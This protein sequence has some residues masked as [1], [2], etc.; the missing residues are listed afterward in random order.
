MYLDYYELD[1]KPFQITTDS[2]F[3]W[4]GGKHKEALATLR[5]GM[6]DNS[7]FLLLTGEEGTGKTILINRL[8]TMLDIGTV[9]ANIPDPDLAS[10]DFYN[11]LADSFQMNRT[12]DSRGAFLIHMRDFLRNCQA[13]QKQVLLIIDESQRL[14]QDIM[15][16]IRKLSNIEMQDG[17]PI[18]IFFVGQQGFNTILK[19]PQNRALAQRITT[20]YHIEPL[21]YEETE[22]YIYH[23]LKMVGSKRQIFE[24]SALPEIF[25]FSGGVPRL[26]NTI[27]DH[28]L[29]AGF[30]QGKKEIDPAIIQECAGDLQIPL[31]KTNIGTVRPASQPSSALHADVTE[32]TPPRRKE[33]PPRSP[34]SPRSPHSPRS[35]VSDSQA[36]SSEQRFIPDTNGPQ[37]SF[38]WKSVFLILVVLLIGLAAFTITQ[39]NQNQ[40]PRWEL[41]ELTP[42]NY[43]TSLEREKELLASRLENRIEEKRRDDS[44]SSAAD[45]Q[46]KSDP[47]ISP[48]TAHSQT[49]SGTS[50]KEGE[51][52]PLP[53][54]KERIV[55]H[56]T[57]NS[58]DIEPE[59]YPILSRIADYLK[60]HQDEIVYV[61]GFTDSSGSSAYNK[62]ISGFRA[63]AVK[64]FLLGRG[65]PADNIRVFSMGAS[66]PIA[67]ND[68]SAGRI[69]NRRVEIEFP[70]SD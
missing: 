61:R 42:K 48:L 5:Y 27:C 28:A 47:A 10:V 2:K 50:L 57:L 22:Q 4:L 59:S 16:D 41:E 24:K 32:N 3:L 44:Q 31:K 49:T 38:A 63:N 21:N 14:N 17:E 1:E 67:S 33:S 39:L 46:E 55:V 9:V 40:G 65:A 43:L 37:S 58:N 64:S 53:L 23:R 12:F 36:A 68:S 29:L 69:Q 7:G 19:A 6:M 60:N 20:R 62:S 34:R 26:I 45:P 8:V 70:P 13:E 54:L 25:S 51:I 56:F 11:L 15:E 30:S 18:N 35:T 52:V 66:S